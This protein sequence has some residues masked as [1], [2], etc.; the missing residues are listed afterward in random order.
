MDKLASGIKKNPNTDPFSR[1]KE[2]IHEL[3][4]KGS[5]LQFKLK[6]VHEKEVLKILKSL[7]Q[8][9]SYGH[10]G[11]SSEVLKLAA[12]ILVIPLTYIINTS[13]ITGKFPTNWKLAK[14]VPLH[15]KGDKK[16]LKNYRPVSLLPVAGMILEKM[17]AIQMEEYFEKNNLL[18]E[19]QFG[20]R[21]H[22]NTT[23]NVTTLSK[24]IP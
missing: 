17:V 20:F 19:F 18:G 24:F 3:R 13:I 6:T 16:S 12:E 7:K 14:I 4:L 5:K 2:K 23:L 8:K 1:L 15:K 10:D 11:I 9:R 22:R 21:Q